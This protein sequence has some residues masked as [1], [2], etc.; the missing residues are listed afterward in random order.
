MTVLLLHAVVSL[1]MLGVIWSVQL[2][3]ALAPHCVGALYTAGDGFARPYH[4]LTAF[5]RKAQSLGVQYR[6]G[7][8]VTELDRP[9]DGWRLVTTQGI[10]EAKTLVNC[11]GAWAGRI[12]ADLGEPVPLVSGAPMMSVIMPSSLS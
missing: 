12:C 10:I 8:R 4:A 11:A 2:V 5:R 6:T 9:G 7:C 3:P 1:M